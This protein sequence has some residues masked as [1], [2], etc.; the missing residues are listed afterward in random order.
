VVDLD[1]VSDKEEEKEEVGERA[2]LLH[3]AARPSGSGPPAA[4]R[5][6]SASDAAVPVFPDPRLPYFVPT[7]V[8]KARHYSGLETVHVNF[9][10]QFRGACQPVDKGGHAGRAGAPSH[11]HA[12]S[13]DARSRVREKRRD[14]RAA[15]AKAAQARAERGRQRKTDAAAATDNRGNASVWHNARLQAAGTGL[16]A[17]ATAYVPQEGLAHSSA[18][19]GRPQHEAVNKAPVQRSSGIRALPHPQPRPVIS[20]GQRIESPTFEDDAIHSGW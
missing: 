20:S 1:A 2:A 9:Y 12:V 18:A 7:H 16:A 10:A 17:A 14:E 11:G 15:Q 19:S 8:L 5:S 3:P 6:S 4:V 13:A